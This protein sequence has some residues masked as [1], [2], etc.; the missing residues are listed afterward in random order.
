MPETDVIPTSA[1][2]AS[3]GKGIRYIG[4]HC[5]AYSGVIALPSSAETY[6][7]FTTGSGYIIAKIKISADW[8]GLGGN[9]LYIAFYINGEQIM[10]ERDT[11]NNYVPG[12]LEWP[13]FLPPRTHL[14][15]KLNASAAQE[16][17][18]IFIGRVY[19][20]G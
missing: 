4:N 18:V 12:N 11:G 1:S 8:S 10:F 13:I 14:E 15:I 7:D 17:D 2:I 16:A 3:T 5:Y 9:E 6:L 19:G 20:A